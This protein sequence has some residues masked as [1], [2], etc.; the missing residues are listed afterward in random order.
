MAKY[1]ER[2]RL[3]SKNSLKQYYV[4]MD[5]K[6]LIESDRQIDD[7]SVAFSNKPFWAVMMFTGYSRGYS[8][9]KIKLMDLDSGITYGMFISD[10]SDLL[11]DKGS[12]V[13]RGRSWGE[14]Q[15]VKRGA[16]YGIRSVG[17]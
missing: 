13:T 10:A 8:S 6:C 3:I 4:D 12:E 15:V 2:V 16:N 11:S 9:C 7:N 17:Q 5:S 14:W 1:G